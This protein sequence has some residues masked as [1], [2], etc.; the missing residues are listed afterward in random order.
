LIALAAASPLV[1][2]GHKREA[3]LRADV[4]AIRVFD[5]ARAD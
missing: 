3:R 2:A 5:A 4:P 1:M